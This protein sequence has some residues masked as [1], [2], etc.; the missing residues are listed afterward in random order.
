MGDVM[1]G[2]DRRR[3][4]SSALDHSFEDEAYPHAPIE[5]RI[6]LAQ[7]RGTI[8][9]FLESGLGTSNS[10]TESGTTRDHDGVSSELR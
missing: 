1:E 2:A 3:M 4:S 6:L 8:R 7:R 5:L 9:K 10:G